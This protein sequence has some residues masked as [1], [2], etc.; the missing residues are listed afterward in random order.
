MNTRKLIVYSSLVAAAFVS[1]PALADAGGIFGWGGSSEVGPYVRV[2]SGA[3]FSRD[4]NSDFGRKNAGD[5]YILDG[6]VG[7]QFTPNFRGDVTV[8]Y[9]GGYKNSNTSVT[10]TGSVDSGGNPISLIT[11]SAVKIKTLPVLLN[12]YMDV[13]K[14]GAFT[15]YIGGGFGFSVNKTNSTNIVTQTSSLLGTFPNTTGTLGGKRTTSAAWQLGAGTS[16]DVY[17]NVKFDIGYQ[18]TY[19][20]TVKTAD[21]ARFSDGS[22][23]PGLTGKSSLSAHEIM[24]GFRFDF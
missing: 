21:V 7:Y 17:K 24:A 10:P 2:D 16:V 9:R 6:G 22:V 19:F 23:V 3:S 12:G 13:G 15:P 20:G 14:F 11:S 4:M 1:Q 8:G 5:S 18:Y